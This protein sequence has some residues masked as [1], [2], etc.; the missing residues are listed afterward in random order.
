MQAIVLAAVVLAAP[1]GSVL[2]VAEGEVVIHLGRA[3]GLEEGQKVRLY[4]RLV[5]KHPI[6]GETLEDRFPIGEVLPAEVGDVLSILRSLDGLTRPVVPGDYAVAVKPDSPAP[7]PAVAERSAAPPP[8][9]AR[10]PEEE[11]IEAAMT[12][13]FGLPLEER[14]KLWRDVLRR[15]PEGRFARSVASEIVTLEQLQEELRSPPP[16]PVAAAAPA[17]T[18]PA[19]PP[20]PPKPNTY[21][22]Y[23][24]PKEMEQGRPA[25][26]AVR[27]AGEDVHGVRLVAR[28]SDQ[29]TYQTWRMQPAGDG[30]WRASVPEELAKEAG[31]VEYFVEALDKDGEPK[32]VIGSAGQPRRLRVEPPPP[33][34]APPGHSRARVHSQLVDFNAGGAADRFWELEGSFEYHLDW[35]FLDMVQVGAGIIDGEGTLG[36]DGHTYLDEEEEGSE[37][38]TLTLNY[39][40]VATDIGMGQWAGV[41]VRLTGGNH[42]AT[43]DGEKASVVGLDGHLRIGR[44]DETR[45][46]LGAGFLGDV[47][48]R[49]YADMH[50]GVFD[51]VPIS[52]G[53]SVTSLPLDAED[54]YGLRLYVQGG[55]KVVDWLSLDAVVGW[56]ARNINHQG[57]TAGGGVT[58]DW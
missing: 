18:R 9:P 44:R 26:L 7:R 12:A 17:A 30:A 34:R 32:P 27:V 53:A 46:E 19:A 28:R 24:D 52:A 41:G 36:D 8:T 45:F 57:Y 1:E 2:Q 10:T 4:R 40:F 3:Q 35:Y 21:A 58:L 48:D 11:T 42:H 55:L 22:G 39:A 13:C 20:P 25:A 43:D 49:F 33:E 50:I 6:S 14:V 29:R 16:A 47:G 56:N 31:T 54:G 23:H 15:F 37:R 51:R 5:V 38:T